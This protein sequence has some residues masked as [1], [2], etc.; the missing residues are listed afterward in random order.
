MR[1]TLHWPHRYFHGTG[2][3]PAHAGNTRFGREP[4]GQAGDHP[5]ACGEHRISQQSRVKQQGSSPRMRGTLFERINDH[6]VDGI[7]PAHA[8]NT[9]S[10]QKSAPSSRDHPRACGEHTQTVP[11][12]TSGA[13]S[14]PRMR[15]TRVIVPV[16]VQP[17]G[18]IPAHAG[19]THIS[20]LSIRHSRDH[21]RACGEHMGINN[22]YAQA[23]GSSPRMRGTPNRNHPRT[24]DAGII[25]AHAGNTGDRA[26]VEAQL[27]DHPRACGEHV[28]ATT[29]QLNIQG[30]SPRM[31]GTP[32]I[33]TSDYDSGGIIPAH[34]GNTRS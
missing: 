29:S 3:I 30:S 15:G 28:N 32:I 12:T 6:E 4:A 5:R 11:P 33:D 23:Q 13:G 16:Q 7:I 14:S 34:A 19:N 26:Y 20:A 18:I 10:S 21:P 25:P 24:P 2:I 8:G 9:V 22:A 27:R 1:G 31:R 17:V